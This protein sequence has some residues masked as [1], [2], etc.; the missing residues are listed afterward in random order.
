VTPIWHGGADADLTF[1]ILSDAP[2]LASAAAASDAILLLAGVTNEDSN[3]PL[4]TN[5]DLA[6]A[7][8]AQSGGRPVFC[9][10]T[11]AV[12]GRA[13]GRLREDRPLQ[14]ITP[15][16]VSK[17]DM[18]DAVR[19]HPNAVILRIGNVAGADALLGVERDHYQLTQFADGSTP[20]RSFIGPGLLART[21]A[22]LA[23]LK[24]KGHAVPQVLN[25][26][27]PVPVSMGALLQAAGKS[28]TATPPGPE[29]IKRVALDT[30]T[31]WGLW[32]DPNPRH[33]AAEIVADLRGSEG[34]R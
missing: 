19:P 27:G 29:N 15:Y 26:A 6:K 23:H 20:L 17:R 4:S 1:D 9:C 8:L 22:R 14:P 21:L 12:Y 33:G 16:G 7:V 2:A 34:A 5:T 24:W 30:D 11:A 3:R 13:E 31:L 25:V 32:D 10:S 18:E 28:W